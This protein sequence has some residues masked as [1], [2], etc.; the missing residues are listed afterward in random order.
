MFQDTAHFVAAEH[1]RQARRARRS[2]EVFEPR[3]FNAQNATIEENDRAECL[4]MRR[5]ADALVAHELIEKRE[6][7]GRSEVTRMPCVKC[8]DAS[9]PSGISTYGL[10][11]VVTV[12]EFALEPVENVRD[13][14]RNDGRRS[15]HVLSSDEAASELRS[16][17][18]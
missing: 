8:R 6:D 15:S 11:T 18:Q 2:N 14:R 12:V 7:V 5:S 9:D 13:V 1:E 16:R 10:G 4:L 3:W 17:L